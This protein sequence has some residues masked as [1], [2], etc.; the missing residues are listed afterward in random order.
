MPRVAG[1]VWS[2]WVLVGWAGGRGHRSGCPASDTGAWGAVHSLSRRCHVVS[3]SVRPLWWPATKAAPPDSAL[4]RE[5]K[6]PVG[7][8]GRAVGGELWRPGWV[9]GRAWRVRLSRAGGGRSGCCGGCL[10]SRPRCPR[11]PRRRPPHVRRRRRAL[12]AP[13]R[14]VVVRPSGHP[15]AG[16]GELYRPVI[17]RPLSAIQL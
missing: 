16:G 7:L 1:P 15:P 4:C 10:C 17:Q 13:H 11:R 14:V 3:A 6:R 8:F 5:V 2:W 12:P 9:G